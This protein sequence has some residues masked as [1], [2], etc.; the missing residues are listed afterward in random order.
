MLVDQASLTT[1]AADLL[2]AY[3]D[4]RWSLGVSDERSREAYVTIIEG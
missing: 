1:V 3:D 4:V 2:D